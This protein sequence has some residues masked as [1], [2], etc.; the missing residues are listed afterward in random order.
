MVVEVEGGIEE[1]GGGGRVVEGWGRSPI[2]I[3]PSLRPKKGNLSLP[4]GC[5][6]VYR[7]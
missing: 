6:S 7:R 4:C 1:G 3:S 5:N 2:F